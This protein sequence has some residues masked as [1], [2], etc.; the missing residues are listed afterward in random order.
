MPGSSHSSGS[1]ASMLER[2][3]EWLLDGLLT[4]G[5]SGIVVLMALESSLV[6]VPAELVMPPAGY[7]VA[8]GEMN[9]VAAVAAGVVGSLLGSL[10][11]YF[12]G[13]VARPRVGAPVREV[14]SHLREIARTHGAVFRVS[15]RDQRPAGQVASRGAPP[16]L[17]SRW[18]CAHAPAGICGLHGRGRVPVVRHP[19]LDRVLPGSA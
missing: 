9:A 4:L 2:F 19:Y 15:R 5:Y 12:R 3:I 16:H 17:D 11:T 6:P 13:H 10:A 18:P 1:T 8:K 7:W 14:L